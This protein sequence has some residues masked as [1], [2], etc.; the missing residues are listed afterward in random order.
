MAA[1]LANVR[2][3]QRQAVLM[4]NERNE[5]FTSWCIPDSFLTAPQSGSDSQ[6]I[7]STYGWM[8]L[9]GAAGVCCLLIVK[10]N[11]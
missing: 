1:I 3:E 2:I 5:G 9:L 7:R 6:Q 8:E 10:V 11:L 4:W